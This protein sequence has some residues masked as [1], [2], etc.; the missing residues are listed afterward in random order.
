MAR[1]FLYSNLYHILR[2]IKIMSQMDF[3]QLLAA[4]KQLPPDEKRKL[5]ES[6]AEQKESQPKKN[7]GRR[8]PPPV[9][10]KDRTHESKWL[11]EYGK[12][13]AGQWVALEGNQLIAHSFNAD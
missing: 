6:L 11:K 13:Y 2:G 3:E 7:L 8:V 9:P 4:V 5:I 12:E 10:S 1:F